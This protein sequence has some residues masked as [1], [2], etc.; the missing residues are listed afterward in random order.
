M[1]KIL[2][3]AILCLSAAHCNQFCLAYVMKG[4]NDAK[5]ALAK[6]NTNEKIDALADILNNLPKA[7]MFCMG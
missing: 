1:I 7:I 6:D 3:L 5:L 2:L 4:L